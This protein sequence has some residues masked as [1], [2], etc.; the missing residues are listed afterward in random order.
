MIDKAYSDIS[1]IS[2]TSA[3]LIAIINQSSISRVP[4]FN[5]VFTPFYL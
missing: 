1:E 4:R 3:A 5:V 2:S